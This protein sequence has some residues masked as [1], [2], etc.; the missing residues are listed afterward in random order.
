MESMYQYRKCEKTGFKKL[1]MIKWK[2]RHFCQQKKNNQDNIKNNKN[3]KKNNE[4]Q[5]ENDDDDH[6]DDENDTRDVLYMIILL[7]WL[8]LY[9][10]MYEV[11]VTSKWS[12]IY[13]RISNVLFHSNFYLILVSLSMCIDFNY[14]K[15]YSN[16][17]K[18]I[19]MINIIELNLILI[20]SMIL[21]C[22]SIL[23]VMI[24][25]E[26]LMQH[27]TLFVS[28]FWMLYGFTNNYI[29]TN[30]MKLFLRKIIFHEKSSRAPDFGKI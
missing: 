12:T 11:F 15:I 7:A 21:I 18:K 28:T 6:G 19:M 16:D 4:Q 26:T 22:Y 1:S 20:N 23:T 9:N 3:N 17:D 2:R 8:V 30:L 13:E 25:S 10:I 14:Y 29:T 27:N 24:E 5:S